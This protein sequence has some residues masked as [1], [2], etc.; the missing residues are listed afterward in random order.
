M[1]A[2][3]PP[4]RALR[5]R[6]SAFAPAAAAHPLLRYRFLLCASEP[7]FRGRR[8]QLLGK[9]LLGLLRFRFFLGLFV[10]WNHQ[11]FAGGASGSSARELGLSSASEATA[12]GARF[13]GAFGARRPLSRG[14]TLPLEDSSA[15]S[16]CSCSRD[17]SSRGRTSEDTGNASA[18]RLV[19]GRKFRPSSSFIEWVDA[20][21]EN[22]SATLQMD[23][24]ERTC[25]ATVPEVM[26][27][28][29]FVPMRHG[30]TGGNHSHMPIFRP[31]ARPPQKVDLH[32]VLREERNAFLGAKSPMS[33]P[34]EVLVEGSSCDSLNVELQ[35]ILV[36]VCRQRNSSSRGWS[37]AEGPEKHVAHVSTDAG[38]VPRC[39]C[40][41]VVEQRP[42]VW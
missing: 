40:S 7:A 14:A 37:K 20:R 21:I 39:R 27:H 5:P 23:K 41:S 36:V 15:V 17:S 9:C 13:F 32:L 16:S 24:L 8:W 4:V 10:P 31:F 38:G 34:A 30:R 12:A 2:R 42:A 33:T 3:P 28:F 26:A 6:T 29:F 35:R 1:A 18:D 11:L 25:M 19:E 22:R